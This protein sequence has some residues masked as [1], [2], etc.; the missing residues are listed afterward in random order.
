MVIPLPAPTFMDA[1]AG[2]LTLFPLPSKLKACP[3]SP[4]LNIGLVKVPL[5]VPW[6]SRAFPSPGHQLTIPLTGGAQVAANNRDEFGDN[7]PPKTAIRH[8]GSTLSVLGRSIC[9]PFNVNLK[10]LSALPLA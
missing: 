3:T 9:H 5:F 8:K 10:S 2:I 4:A 6:I 1:E 7:K